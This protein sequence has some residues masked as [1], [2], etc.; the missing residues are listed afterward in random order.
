[1][2]IK[3]SKFNLKG[4]MKK[5]DTLENMTVIGDED[6]V[7]LWEP[8][9]SGKEYLTEALISDFKDHPMIRDSIER[10]NDILA[11][12]NFEEATADNKMKK[13]Q[14]FADILSR[15]YCIYYKMAFYSEDGID[16]VGFYDEG[17]MSEEEAENALK[18]DMKANKERYKI[19]TLMK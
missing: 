11:K 19:E 5:D 17:E 3:N 6:F 9:I 15:F 4:F 10:V 7:M 8:Y 14:S 18:A 2:D 12:G 1:M 13:L 16:L